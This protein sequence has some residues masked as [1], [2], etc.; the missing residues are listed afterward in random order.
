MKGPNLVLKYD[1]ASGSLKNIA[2]PGSPYEAL[3]DTPGNAIGV[4][5]CDLDGD[6]REE[7]YFLNTNQ[8]IL[9]Q[10]HIMYKTWFS[11]FWIGGSVCNH[12]F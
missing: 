8:V 3:M 4:A 6:G 5:A 2:V 11:T 9:V 1:S 12:H 10:V 7:I